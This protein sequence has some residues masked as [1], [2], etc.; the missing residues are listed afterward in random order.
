MVLEDLFYVK[1]CLGQNWKIIRVPKL[2][3][4]CLDA[5]SHQAA[6]LA[7]EFNSQG[8]PVNDPRVTPLGRVLRKYWIDELPQ[9]YNLAIGDLKLVG[10]RPM[11]LVDWAKY[12][13]DIMPRALKQ[14]PG[15]MGIQYAYPE[16]G[17]FED[18]VDH[19]REYLD[20]WE[21]DSGKTDRSYF[22]RIVHN[23]LVGGIRSS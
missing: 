12:P 20:A 3:T 16:T 22:C 21:E 18:H 4:M 13:E 6:V 1:A 11:R 9:L 2:R 8:R 17:R 23:I 7:G 19:L 15:L 5:N 14:K 10:I